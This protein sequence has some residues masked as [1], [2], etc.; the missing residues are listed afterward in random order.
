MLSLGYDIGSSSIKCAIFDCEGGKTIARGSHPAEEMQIEA[1]RQGWAEQDPEVWWSYVATLTRQL[2]H[3]NKIDPMR[4]Q[5]I[6]ISYQMHGLVLV[7]EDLRVLRPSIIWCDSRA[8]DIGRQAFENLGNEFC[9]RRLLNSPGNFTASKLRWVKENEAEVY[10]KV[11]KAMLPG[12]FIAMKLT[13]DVITTVSGLSEGIYWDFKK[14]GVSTELLEHFQIEE[15]LLPEVRPTF[16]IQGHVTKS[17]AQEL[18]LR[19]GISVAYRAGDQPNNAFSL[20]VLDPGEAAATAGTSGVVYAVAD[21]ITC[22]MKSRVNPF[23]HVNHSSDQPRLGVL[24]CINGTGILNS[25]LRRNV[26]AGLSYDEINA[27]AATIEV[28]S[29]G[30][31]VIPFGNGAERI[32]ENRNIGCQILG[33]DFNRHSQAHLLRASQE[34]I[35]FSFKYGLEIMQ[36]MGM[37]VGVIR[38]GHAN[39]FLSPLFRQTLADI[40][41]AMIE[42]YD[43]D[44]AEGAARGRLSELDSFLHFRTHSDRWKR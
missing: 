17:A 42:L 2:V 44:G 7:D 27:S 6:G 8:V 12:E 40:T 3:Q 24:L 19:E 21:K 29:E 43:T 1:P 26:A 13:G 18:G 39:M 11:Y 15:S 37:H 5:T 9:L 35:A 31:A 23:A 32:L 38:A 36:E 4:I 22:D 30:L 33:L 20:G 14:N 41:G 28:G 34:G 10:K 16:S 25:W